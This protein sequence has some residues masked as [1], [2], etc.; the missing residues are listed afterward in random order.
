MIKFLK[1]KGKLNYFELFAIFLCIV[2]AGLIVVFSI[3]FSR[4]F[5]ISLRHPVEHPEI[6]GYLGD[7][8]AGIIGPMLS[9]SGVL[10]LYSAL[11]HQRKEIKIN[12]DALKAQIEEFKGQKVELELTRQVYEEQSQTF[13][14]QRFETTFFNLLESYKD[15]RNKDLDLLK[16]SFFESMEKINFKEKDRKLDGII[17]NK[18]FLEIYRY[19]ESYFQFTEMILKHIYES[20]GKEGEY[21]AHII[22]AM[23]PRW[24]KT[25][26]FYYGLSNTGLSLKVYLEIFNF[27]GWNF[28]PSIIFHESHQ[29][30]YQHLDTNCIK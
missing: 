13:S 8:L 1:E 15:I 24:E 9:I 2:S 27:F 30:K 21:Y 17:N 29:Y 23:L 3:G 6:F 11:I 26:L 20:K 28:D 12:Q 25:T 16:K 18:A 22:Y 10:L 7:F 4:G 14:Q 19:F 5:A